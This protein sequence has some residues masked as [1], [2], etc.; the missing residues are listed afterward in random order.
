MAQN[1]KSFK[2]LNNVSDPNRNGIEWLSVADNIDVTSEGKLQL[3][4]GL[5]QRLVLSNVVD[6]F[7]TQ[8]ASRMYVVSSGYLR[9]VH[10]AMSYTDIAVVTGTGIGYWCEFNNDVIYNNG[11]DAFVIG[12]D[13][14]TKPLRWSEVPA[15]TLSPASG[16]VPPGLY[17]VKYTYMLN[18]GRETGAGPA[19]AIQL[20][21]DSAISIT[22][23]PVSSDYRVRVYIAPANSTVFQFAGTPTG[24][25]FVWSGTPDDLIDDLKTDGCYALPLGATCIQMWK[26]RLYASTYIASEDI[27]VVWFSE[28]LGVHLFRLAS[29]FFMVTGKVEMLADHDQALIVGTGSNVYAYTDEGIQALSEYGV[30]PGRP[31]AYDSEEGDVYVWTDRGIC[32]GLPW[33]NMTDEFV[34]FPAGKRASLSLIHRGGEKKLI[35]NLIDGGTAFNAYN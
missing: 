34:S 28:P 35:A 22:G 26:G 10:S 17:Q 18:D 8:D 25:S 12:P 5:T 32:S 20:D 24:S 13:G 14:S 33:R 16:S 11:E 23:I 19:S 2:G 4:P 3:R 7:A 1:I 29:D 15:P 30:P 21:D 6:A 27:S 31:Y 9:S